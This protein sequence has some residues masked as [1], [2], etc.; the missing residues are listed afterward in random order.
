MS[1]EGYDAANSLKKKTDYLGE[2]FYE[3]DTLKFINHEEGRIVMTGSEPEYQYT[4]KDH[5]GNT[6]ITFTS[7]QEAE[8]FKAT[9]DT[10]NQEKEEDDFGAYNSFINQPL[11]PSPST[12]VDD[13]ILILN[14]GYAGRIGLTKS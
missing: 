1:Q 8:E 3:N 14:G 9:L 12:D 10:Q 4:L 6:R 2:F 13:R 11:D 7:K 5:L